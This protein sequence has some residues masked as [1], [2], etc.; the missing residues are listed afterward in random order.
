M[1]EA[2]TFLCRG[3]FLKDLDGS[4]NV[5]VEEGHRGGSFPLSL[6]LQRPEERLDVDVRPSSYPAAQL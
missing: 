2:G 6:L 4:A 3:S 5:E 1:L